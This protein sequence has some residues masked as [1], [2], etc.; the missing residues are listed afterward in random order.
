MIG[1]VPADYICHKKS[2]AIKYSSVFVVDL[3]C[4]WCIDDLCSDDNGSW[5]HDGKPRK[6]YNVEFD[7]RGLAIL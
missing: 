6:D 5:V 1:S 7:G 4:V 2:T 3:A